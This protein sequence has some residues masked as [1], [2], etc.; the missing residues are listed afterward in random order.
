MKGPRRPPPSSSR[1]QLGGSSLVAA[2]LVAACS[3]TSEPPAERPR[4]GT[5][6]APSMPSLTI[7][8]PQAPLELS[9][10]EV[11]TIQVKVSPTAAYR[12]RLA[13][14]GYVAGTAPDGAPPDD[15]ALD[16]AERFSDAQGVATFQLTAP[17]S[18]GS[19]TLRAQVGEQFVD[20]EFKVR[21]D[22]LVRVAVH[23]RYSGR[24]LL[25]QWQ[26]SA[27]V[28]ASCHDRD[29]N[30]VSYLISAPVESL[31]LDDLP[32]ASPIAI[33]AASGLLARGCA[34][35]EQP[36]ANAENSLTV[37]VAD[38][39]VDLANAS[40]DVELELAAKD[41]A[42][43]AALD[44]AIA[45]VLT[46]LQGDSASDTT[47]V[48]DE[49]DLQLPSALARE[50]FRAA[51][52]AASWDTTLFGRGAETRLTAAIQRWHDGG[53]KL[54]LAPRAFEGRL[55]GTAN[56]ERPAFTLSRVGSMSAAAASMTTRTNGWSIDASDTLSFSVSLL[57][58]PEM[59]AASM[60]TSAAQAETGANDIPEALASV[61]RC[62]SLG[63]TLEADTRPA[64]TDFRGRC[65]ASCLEF[66]CSDALAAIWQR[67]SG[68]DSTGSSELS[69][70]GTGPVDVEE[71]D[72]RVDL[73]T[74]K[75]S[76]A[77]RLVRGR[78]V[79]STGGKLAGF[80]PK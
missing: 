70:L 69:I 31:R 78:E 19:F 43:T 66:A 34:T 73:G 4:V 25:R 11:R 51:R 24:R 35:L 72:G 10:R 60:A 47:A 30:A 27:T 65:D 71:S 44:S 38:E 62:A 68:A 20:T 45:A 57:F 32:L 17:S 18:S 3:S 14:L 80:H 75:G 33:T 28:G 22:G 42:F 36:L 37:D 40:L 16:R 77:G 64:V 52:E 55:T 76:W 46:S 54:L 48:L 21:S 29:P 23:P 63:A 74:L 15:A 58:Y 79:A 67:A 7:T 5:G 2:L 49:I 26:A 53:R 6:G 1:I 8:F 39:P 59:L 61:M 50:A 13:L 56:V 41:P 9:P 12:V